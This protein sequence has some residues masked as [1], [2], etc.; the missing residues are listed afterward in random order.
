M[1]KSK[2]QPETIIKFGY[3]KIER[4]LD[5]QI[6]DL[7]RTRRKFLGF[8]SKRPPGGVPLLEFALSL[9]GNIRVWYRDSR[10]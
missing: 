9:S 2:N 6:R 8:L 10:T 7:I 1:T 3:I 4:F 5:L